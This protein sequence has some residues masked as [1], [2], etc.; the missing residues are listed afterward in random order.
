MNEKLMMMTDVDY[1]DDDDDDDDGG[2][3]RS[4]VSNSSIIIKLLVKI[5]PE[6]C[7]LTC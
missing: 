7:I 6:T 4:Y 2:P 5:E 1:D 3:L